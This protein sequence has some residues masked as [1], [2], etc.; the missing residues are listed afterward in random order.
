MLAI[1]EREN[2][3]FLS[4]V[5]LLF[6]YSFPLFLFLL[7][8]LLSNVNL[9]NGNLPKIAKGTRY[10]RLPPTALC[11]RYFKPGFSNTMFFRTGAA[12]TRERELAASERLR[13]D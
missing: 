10:L 11:N 6:F 9:R 12:I 4:L 5:F 3:L 2:F 13:C 8:L 7:L 1:S